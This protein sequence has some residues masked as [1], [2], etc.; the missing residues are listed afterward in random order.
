MLEYLQFHISKV[1]LDYERW[2]AADLSFLAV[3]LQVTLIINPV[4]GC[5][6]FLPGPRLLSQPK[7]SPPP[8]G[9]YQVILLGD[10]GTQV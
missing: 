7:R 4:V 2:G 8:L 5:H 10:R 1:V 9:Q 6:Y 3:S